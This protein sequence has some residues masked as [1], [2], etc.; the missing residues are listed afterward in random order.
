MKELLKRLCCKIGWH[1]FFVGFELTGFDG[2]SFH[3][4]CK[5]CGYKGMIDSQGNLF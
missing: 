4:K 2:A 5:G 1:S 3:A